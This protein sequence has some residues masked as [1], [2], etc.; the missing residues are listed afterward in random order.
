M[1]S[2]SEE[3]WLLPVGNQQGLKQVTFESGLAWKKEPNTQGVVA[4]PQLTV[5]KS[6]GVGEEE[7]ES[8]EEP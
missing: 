4:H 7:S 1:E 2:R 8:L 6:Q 3:K 5:P